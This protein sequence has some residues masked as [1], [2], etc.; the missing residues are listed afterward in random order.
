MQLFQRVLV[1]LIVLA[2][3][4]GCYWMADSPDRRMVRDRSIPWDHS[5]R[6]GRW[7]E[8]A[9]HT[10][11]VLNPIAISPSTR[12][13]AAAVGE[14]PQNEIQVLDY[15]TGGVT[16]IR[17][18]SGYYRVSSPTFSPDGSL[19]AFVA[20]PPSWGGESQVVVFDLA[21]MQVMRIYGGPGEYVETI[22][23]SRSGEGL[24]VFA[25]ERARAVPRAGPPYQHYREIQRQQFGYL[26]LETGRIEPLASVLT[27]AGRVLTET[28][29]GHIWLWLDGVFLPADDQALTFEHPDFCE[30]LGQE[31]RVGSC[32]GAFFWVGT[33][34][35]PYAPGH[36][37]P[38]PIAAI[39]GG[40][41]LAYAPRD[42]PIGPAPLVLCDEPGFAENIRC[43]QPLPGEPVV[44]GANPNP[45][46]L[47]RA[48]VGG[49]PTLDK[50]DPNA[51]AGIKIV[52]TLM[53]LRV[54]VHLNWPDPCGA[55]TMGSD[56]KTVEIR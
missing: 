35:I 30:P 4:A 15:D 34:L 37:M 14:T 8:N 56:C 55:L 41:V 28:A 16:R 39:P 51:A 18:R 22:R 50:E 10:N 38:R 5:D 9:A 29:D 45:D 21:A 44:L 33:D 19:L 11:A 49:V 20:A 1:C 7:N 32:A 43:G 54:S 26:S 24:F 13:L 25:I 52:E 42:R 6:I 3:A 36:S 17:F 12:Q 2:G 27:R 31:W 48:I 46:V 47:N 53:D 23:F 40:R